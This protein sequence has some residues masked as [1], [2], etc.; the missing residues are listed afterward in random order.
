MPRPK[1]EYPEEKVKKV[2]VK[3]NKELIADAAQAK[4]KGISYGEYKTEMI[5]DR[6]E[7]EFA[8]AKAEFKLNLLKQKGRRKNDKK[9]SKKV[10]VC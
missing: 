4:R 6:Q 2:N 8:A 1:K 5:K 7:L 9:D 3:R 10:F